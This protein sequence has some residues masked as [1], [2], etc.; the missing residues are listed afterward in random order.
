MR[1]TILI[2]VVMTS[3]CSK[4][5]ASSDKQP[6]PEIANIAATYQDLQKI[7]PQPVS[8]ALSLARYCT[9]VQP[10][11]ITEKYGPH[12]LALIDVYMNDLAA[13]AFE[14]S[15][16]SYSVGSVIVKE[17]H[18][19]NNGVDGVGGMVKRSEGYDIGHGNWEY[20]YFEDIK[21][22]NTGKLENCI[23]CH[24]GAVKKDFIFGDW[25]N[26]GWSN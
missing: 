17:K 7:T 9:S 16:N 26:Q 3:A 25:A 2:V 13:N 4:K 1:W 19:F 21:N 18:G 12:A 20:F 15:S 22:I 14:Q 6:Q 8:V 11:A 5:T 10:K 24:V 23:Q